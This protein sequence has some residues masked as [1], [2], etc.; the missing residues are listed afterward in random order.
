MVNM[1]TDSKIFVAG[2]RGLV[3]SAIKRVLVEHGYKNI[4]TPTS[5]ELDLRDEKSVFQFFE[6]QEPE[7]VFLAAAKV[8]GIYANNTYP[9]DFLMDNLRIQN[10]VI[11]AAYKFKSKKLLFLGSSCIYPK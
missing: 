9:V 11:E 7:F 5:C 1:K 3:G 6:S 10:N 4:L 8:G 2:G